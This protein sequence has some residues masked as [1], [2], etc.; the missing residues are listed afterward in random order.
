MPTI[1]TVILQGNGSGLL[2]LLSLN[3]RDCYLFHQS[4]RDHHEQFG[5]AKNHI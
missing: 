4:S 1:N 3:P 2:G 5:L